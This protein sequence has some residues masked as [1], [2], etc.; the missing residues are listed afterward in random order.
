MNKHTY[1]SQATDWAKAHGFTHIKANTD[2]FEKPITYGRQQD[3]ESFVPDA[4]G[5]QF[6]QKSYFEVVLKTD[7]TNRL[8]SKLKLLGRLAAIQGGQLY[9]M[10]PKGHLPFAKAIASDCCVSAE[11]VNLR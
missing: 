5:R 8:R 1:I 2:G 6:G 11:M 4:T 10:V 7:D 3:G 9:L